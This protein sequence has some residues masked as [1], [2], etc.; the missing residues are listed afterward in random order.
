MNDSVNLGPMHLN[1]EIENGDCKTM[2]LSVPATVKKII[3]DY[4]KA[5]KGA[6]GNKSP[7]Q[8]DLIIAMIGPG[9]QALLDKTPQ[10]EIMAENRKQLLSNKKS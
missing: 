4:Q 5:F 7:N 6:T 2:V 9:A 8:H 10:L 3:E 1:A